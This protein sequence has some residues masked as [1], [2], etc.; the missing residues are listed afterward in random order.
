[1]FISFSS[2]LVLDA[3]LTPYAVPFRF[4]TAP[5]FAVVTTGDVGPSLAATTPLFP[6]PS[7]T[8]YPGSRTCP[9]GLNPAQAIAKLK[10]ELAAE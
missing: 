10:L 4:P 6:M 7:T 8:K 2:S 5:V 9:K 1:M 3:R